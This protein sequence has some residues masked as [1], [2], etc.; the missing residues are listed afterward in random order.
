[1]AAK[2]LEENRSEEGDPVNALL[3]YHSILQVRSAGA[4]YFILLNYKL[5]CKVDSSDVL[6]DHNSTISGLITC[7]RPD[8]MHLPSSLTCSEQDPK[9]ARHAHSGGLHRFKCFSE[10]TDFSSVCCRRGGNTRTHWRQ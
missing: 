4:F 8:L 6:A 9:H 5:H 1:M 3:L 10:W 2:Q 7:C